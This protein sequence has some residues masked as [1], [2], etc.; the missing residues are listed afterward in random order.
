MKQ[1]QRM[2]E[3]INLFLW[4]VADGDTVESKIPVNKDMAV[5]QNKEVQISKGYQ[6]IAEIHCSGR[7][8]A[9]DIEY[10]PSYLV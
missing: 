5:I 1:I 7:M 6:H 4:Y 10:P 8:Y 2:K 3:F 9:F